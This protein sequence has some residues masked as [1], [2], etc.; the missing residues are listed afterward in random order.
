MSEQSLMDLLATAVTST[1][2]EPTPS[3]KLVVDVRVPKATELDEDVDSDYDEGVDGV[4]R[5]GSKGKWTAAEDELLKNAVSDYG[6]RNWKKISECLD[7]RTDVQCLHRWQKVLRPGLI[8]GP[9]TKEEDDKVVELVAKFGVKSWSHIARELKGRLGKQCRERWY[10]HLSP[11]INKAP[12]TL[13]EDT[14]IVEVG[15]KRIH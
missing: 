10:N 4:M 15:G 9:W 11:D 13:E 5:S 12:W 3:S 2:N 6:G 1:R 14:I 8:K 7:G